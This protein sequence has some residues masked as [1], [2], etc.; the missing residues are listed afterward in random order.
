MI[1]REAGIQRIKREQGNAVGRISTRF[2]LNSVALRG[3]APSASSVAKLRGQAPW[4]RSVAKLRGQPP[5]QLR[6]PWSLVYLHPWTP[7]AVRQY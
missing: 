7:H 2:W 3:Q 1:P 5:Q 4:P 6:G